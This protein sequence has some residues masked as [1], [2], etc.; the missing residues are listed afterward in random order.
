MKNLV[1]FTGILVVAILAA[2]Q[3]RAA[4][5]AQDNFDSYANGDLP[6]VSSGAW[7]LF[8]GTAGVGDVQVVSGQASLSGGRSGD[9]QILLSGGPYPTTSLF[10]SFDLTVTALPLANQGAYLSMFKDSGTTF[11]GKTFSSNV[12]GQ[13]QLGVSAQANNPNS[14]ALWGTTFAVGTTHKIVVEFDQS[15]GLW[16]AT[17]TMWVDPVNMASTS[18]VTTDHAFG[19]NINITAFA[20]RES[21]AQQGSQLIDNVLVGTTFGDVVAVP[22]PS[23]IMLLCTGLLGLWAIR[24]RS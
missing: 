11:L 8:S 6:T 7:S 23:T 2:T 5:L 24:R 12:A 22:E 17:T 14:G 20:F 4:I 16:P 9:D 10:Y 19:T 15:S 1:R 13:V 21:N 18:I 3:A